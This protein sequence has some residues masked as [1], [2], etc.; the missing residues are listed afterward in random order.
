VIFWIWWI[1]YVT[2]LGSYMSTYSFT[3]LTQMI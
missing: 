3:I 1:K 2:T